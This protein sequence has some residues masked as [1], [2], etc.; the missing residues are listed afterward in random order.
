VVFARQLP[1]Y[2]HDGMPEALSP[3]RT[4]YRVLEYFKI[5]FRWF[6]FAFDFD[7]SIQGAYNPTGGAGGYSILKGDR[8]Q[9]LSN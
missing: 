4:E 9:V 2:V 1:M 3:N 5:A 7:F 8:F 6:K